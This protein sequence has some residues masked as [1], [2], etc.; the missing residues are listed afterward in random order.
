MF[1]N[2]IRSVMTFLSL[3]LKS[4][5]SEEVKERECEQDVQ[6]EE[7]RHLNKPKPLFVSISPSKGCVAESDDHSTGETI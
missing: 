4:K 7:K 3:C 5:P 6:K 1:S 2:R